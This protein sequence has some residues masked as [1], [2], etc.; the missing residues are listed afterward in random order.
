MNVSFY[1]HNSFTDLQLSQAFV[2][3]EAASVYVYAVLVSLNTISTFLLCFMAMNSFADQIAAQT[4]AKDGNEENLPLLS[5]K[6]FF[7]NAQSYQ[8]FSF[9]VMLLSVS[10]FT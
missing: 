9:Q 8:Y 6:I 2:G 7:K 3:F 10:M 4:C 1:F 5:N